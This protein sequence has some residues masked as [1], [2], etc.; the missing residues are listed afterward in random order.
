MKEEILKYIET[1]IAQ[2]RI[3]R[4]GAATQPRYKAMADG[5]L[6]ELMIIKQFIE[7]EG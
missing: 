7:K 2:A 6:A 5:A 3:V 4:K 1:R